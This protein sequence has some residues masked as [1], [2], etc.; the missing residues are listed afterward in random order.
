MLK[1]QSVS[2]PRTFLRRFSSLQ[3]DIDLILEQI[4]FEAFVGIHLGAGGVEIPGLINSDLYNTTVGEKLNA[5]NLRGFKDASIDLIE[6]HHMIEHL[7]FAEFEIALKEWFRVLRP[8]GYLIISCPDI[9]SVSA[10]WLWLAIKN[11]FVPCADERLYTLK[12]IYGSQEHNGMFHKSGYDKSHL[13][14][15]LEKWGFIVKFAYSPYPK[16]RTPSLLVIAK[17]YKVSEYPEGG[18]NE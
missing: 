11:K 1:S 16:R 15:L 5:I 9:T 8:E 2:Y 18:D 3:K 12:M 6:T 7:S 14:M 4:R 17:K 10:R 13:K